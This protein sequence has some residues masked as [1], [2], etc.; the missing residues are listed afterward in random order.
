MKIFIDTAEVQE[1]AHYRA[2]GQILGITTNPEIL[3]Q[4]SVSGNPCDLHNSADTPTA[5]DKTK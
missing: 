5:S 3:G 2:L 1:I 4:F